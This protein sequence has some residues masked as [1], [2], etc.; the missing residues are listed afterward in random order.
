MQLTTMIIKL[1]W[2]HV[3]IIKSYKNKTDGVMLHKRH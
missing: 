1:N 2:I 3:Y